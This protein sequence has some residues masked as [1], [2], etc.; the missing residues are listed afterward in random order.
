MPRWR[1]MRSPQGLATGF[2]DALR[3]LRGQTPDERASWL[4]D[5][6][7]EHLGAIAHAIDDAHHRDT[8]LWS[9]YRQFVRGA[10]G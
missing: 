1:G 10:G 3:V 4:A 8:E 9:E 7:R 2:S 6:R 5:Q